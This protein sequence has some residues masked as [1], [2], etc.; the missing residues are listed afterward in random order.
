MHTD[1]YSLKYL[2]NQRMSTIPQHHWASKLLG[3]D[4][5]VEYQPG[6]TNTVIDV[7]SLHDTEALDKVMAISM[8]SF[9]LFDD[10]HAEHK[11]DSALWSAV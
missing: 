11:E 1:H 5:T 3:F 2:L 6:S 4:F 8:P 7:L 9:H 10:L